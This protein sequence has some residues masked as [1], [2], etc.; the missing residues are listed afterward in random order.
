MLK[1]FDKVPISI[2]MALIFDSKSLFS[3][4]KQP[5]VVVFYL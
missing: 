4:S 3:V 2:C 1:I 5:I